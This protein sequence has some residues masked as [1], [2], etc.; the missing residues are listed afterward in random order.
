MSN[1]LETIYIYL[2]D[3]LFIYTEKDVRIC[4]FA[5]K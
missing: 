4:F 3:S 5:K 2:I 1:K